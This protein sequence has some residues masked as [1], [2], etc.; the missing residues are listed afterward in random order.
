MVYIL[1]TLFAVLYIGL[2]IFY[3]R[4]MSRMADI[5]TSRSEAYESEKGKNIA[6]KEDIEEITKRLESVKNEISF[7]KQRENKFI[8]ERYTH[9]QLFFKYIHKVHSYCNLLLYYLY[10]MESKDRLITLLHETNENVT[11]VSYEQQML[12]AYIDDVEINK[13][14][15]ETVQRFTLYSC[16]IM[17]TMSNAISHLSNYETMRNLAYSHGDNQQLLAVAIASKKEFENLKATYQGGQSKESKEFSAY[18]DKVV[19][20]IKDLFS[21]QYPNQYGKN[22]D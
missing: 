3:K 18:L 4:L 20:L 9:L 22:A 7:A 11:N 5:A 16:S 17:V 10:D 12:H 6:T 2:C 15:D 8:M 19:I 14:L 1:S 13:L 21:K